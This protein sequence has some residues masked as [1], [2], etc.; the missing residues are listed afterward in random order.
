M[1]V[2]L[3][4]NNLWILR[5]NL[6]LHARPAERSF[7]SSER[8]QDPSRLL[9]VQVQVPQLATDDRRDPHSHARVDDLRGILRATLLNEGDI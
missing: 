5:D 6:K 7:S 1:N 2:Y 3:T 9:A 4:I 8:S